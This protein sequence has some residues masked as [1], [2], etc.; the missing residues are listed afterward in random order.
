MIR[1][2]FVPGFMAELL[3]EGARWCYWYP[4]R[5][6][7]Q[8]MSHPGRLAAARLLGRIYYRSSSKWRNV[9]LSELKACSS[10]DRNG[11]WLSLEE[12]SRR[13]AE[14]FYQTQA[15][16]FSYPCL[17]PADAR[18][19]FPVTGSEHLD[20][21][22]RQGRGALILL[23][24]IGANQ[25]I[26]PALGFRGYQI[27]QLSRPAHVDNDEYAGQRLSSVL[28][29]IINMQRAYEEALPAKHIDVT[30]GLLPVFRR[31]KANGIVALAGDGRYGNEWTPH[32]F[33][34]RPAT[35]SPGLWLIAH[36]TGAPVLPTF[37]LRPEGGT[38]YQMTIEAPLKLPYG[39]GE[40]EFLAVGLKSYISRLEDYFY[41][42]PWQYMPFLFLARCYTKGHRNRFFLDYPE[43][44]PKDA[45]VSGV[46]P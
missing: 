22:L 26:M 11:S 46:L 38:A 10:A 15:E 20:A 30:K 32:T 9:T 36:R 17:Q 37:M 43:V 8:R 34:G 44:L 2:Q 13:G 24:H 42:Y 6:M 39:G 41:R 31:L 18:K 5:S 21:A 27:F 35:F 16:V 28:V 29:K 45:A 7:V 14:Q 3:K 4:W 19:Y 1:M 40:D 25:M 23:S 12:I 33:L